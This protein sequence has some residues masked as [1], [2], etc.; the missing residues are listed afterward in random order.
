[1]RFAV[2]SDIHSNLEGLQAVLEEA[3][4]RGV[5][6]LLCCGDI[7]GYGAD[8]NACVG[9]VRETGARCIQGNHER[10]LRELDEGLEPNMNPVAMEAL[11]FTRA[12]LGD[13]HRE[14][15]LSLPEE[16]AVEDSLY[17]FHGSPADPDEYVF[18]SFD[19]AYAL[20]ALA[21]EYPPPANFL[22]FIG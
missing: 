17:L 7:V 20:K 21:F 15:L 16:L 18:D 12:A 19:A 8:P 22:C 10:G 1:M 3:E 11:H 2:F 4:R 14:W 6:A 5:D 13:D 9:L